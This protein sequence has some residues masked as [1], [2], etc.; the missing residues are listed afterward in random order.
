[1]PLPTLDFLLWAGVVVF[2]EASQMPLEYA[3]PSLFRGDRVVI[4][5]DEKQLPPTSFFSSQ[6]EEEEDNE[7][8]RFEPDEE[9]TEEQ[10]S[11]A[12]DAWNRREIKDCPDLLALGRSVLDNRMLEVHYRSRYRQLIAYSNA[13]FYA[14]RLNIPVQHPDEEI[15]HLRPIEVLRVDGLYQDQRN[16]QEAL[17][18]VD[19]L[20]QIWQQEKRP[21][22]GIVTFNRKQ[23][24]LIEK[25]L[26]ERAE[27]DRAFQKAWQQELNRREDGEDM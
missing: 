11:L 2:D 4:S 8:D 9:A 13:A 7:F 27:Q 10:I 20:A 26:L 16:N 21:S 1:M 25:R 18:V 3:L 19:L 22:T 15:R 14:G 12:E 24:A 17:Q 6:V 5:G 23:A